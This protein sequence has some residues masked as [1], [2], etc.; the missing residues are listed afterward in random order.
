M[1]KKKY[2]H[3]ELLELAVPT[4]D[5]YERDELYATS[6]GNVFVEKVRCEEHARSLKENPI[7]LSRAALPIKPGSEEKARKDAEA[8]AEEERLAAEKVAKEEAEKESRK[9]AEAKAEEERLEAEKAA[10]EEAEEEARKDTEAKAE[11]ER[12]AA[13]KAAK[14]EAPKEANVVKPKAK[15]KPGPKPTK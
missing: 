10:K 5:R 14:E 4:F 1:S 6:D 11:E 2:S 9:D 12:L 15:S 7:V 3:S 13:E 8:K